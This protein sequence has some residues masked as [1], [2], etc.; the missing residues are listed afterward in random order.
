MQAQLLPQHDGEYER[1]IQMGLPQPGTILTLDDMVQSD[2]CLFVATGI[3]DGMLLQG[4]RQRKGTAL[5][6]SFIAYGGSHA[7]FQFIE[8]YH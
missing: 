3:T 1:C 7:K 5:T 2:D 8:S 4:V 6:H